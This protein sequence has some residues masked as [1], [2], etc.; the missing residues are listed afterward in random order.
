MLRFDIL[1]VFPEM[2]VSPFQF[3]LLKK[4]RKVL[5]LAAQ[6]DSDPAVIKELEA[7]AAA[8]ARRWPRLG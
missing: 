1:S 7:L 8:V 6:P 4:A 5:I 2:F 3:S